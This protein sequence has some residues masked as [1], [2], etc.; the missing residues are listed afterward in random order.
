MTTSSLIGMLAPMAAY[1]FVCFVV[2]YFIFRDKTAAV[3]KELVK[4]LPFLN[5]WVPKE[6][7]ATKTATSSTT[8]TTAL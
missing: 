7:M 5:P 8:T 1:W 4:L 2:F 3:M 6:L